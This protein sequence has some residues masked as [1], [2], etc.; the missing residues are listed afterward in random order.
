MHLAGLVHKGKTPLDAAE[1][2]IEIDLPEIKVAKKETATLLRKHGG[3]TK[4]ELEGA[5][6]VAEAS[7]PEPPTDK[8]PDISIHEAAKTGNIKAVKQALAAGVDVN[9]KDEG[10]WTPLY[11]A[12][13]KE[14]TE[15]LIENGANVNAKDKDGY[16]PLDWA[17][18]RNHPETAD[19]LRKHGG[20]TKEE[21]KTEGK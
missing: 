21:L 19:L 6:P 9:A 20:K 5:E 17:T 4:L 1:M 3:N 10:G 16:T 11:V 13:N 8:A 18:Q 14:F 2:E 15:L 7:Q 12:K